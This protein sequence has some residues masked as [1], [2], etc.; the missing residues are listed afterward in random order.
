MS[1]EH[2]VDSLFSCFEI[3]ARANF[4]EDYYYHYTDAES[5]LSILSEGVIYPYK[6]KTQP[7][8]FGSKEFIFLDVFPHLRIK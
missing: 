6:L 1:I 5:A 3:C 4:R 7:E 8:L 2:E